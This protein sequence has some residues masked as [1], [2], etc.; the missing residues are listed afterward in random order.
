MN[1]FM[2]LV[3]A[4]TMV[5]VLPGCAD[6]MNL[7]DITLTLAAGVDLNEKNEL[8]YY[9]SSPVFNK[10]AKDKEEEYGVEA[11][12][13]K[14]SRRK[15]DNVV[16]ALTVAGKLQVMLI[17]KRVLEHPDWFVV[18][19]SFFRDAR[20]SLNARVAIVDGPVSEV[21]LFSPKD[22]PRLPIHLAKLIDT[23]N[24]RN[25]MVRKTLLQLHR[26]MKERGITPSVP[27]IKKKKNV[28]VAG[29]ALLNHKGQ[30]VTRLA[31]HENPLLLILQRKMQ[32]GDTTLTLTMPIKPGDVPHILHSNTTTLALRNPSV[33]TKTSFQNGRFR[34][35]VHVKVPAVISERLFP[36][37]MRKQFKQFEQMVEKEL[38][39]QFEILVRKCQ[40]KQLDPFG[41]GIYARAFEYKQWKKVED[42]WGEA[43]AK[44]EVKLTVKAQI[45]GMGSVK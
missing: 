16:T 41:F 21:I 23:A 2:A 27:I 18:T 22:K 4:V 36:M 14:Q 12:T 7:E 39:R 11:L 13:F 43:F 1:R 35:D 6:Q 29:T 8:V 34:F 17:G 9:S 10:E 40:Q 25:N 26:E 3:I 31:G 44:S 33:K 42:N 28:N 30:Y 19:D 20:N 37:D 24:K 32:P 45:R 38:Q 5:V 15:L